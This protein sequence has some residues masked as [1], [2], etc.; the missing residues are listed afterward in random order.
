[1]LLKIDVSTR[2]LVLQIFINIQSISMLNYVSLYK[3]IG[4]YFAVKQVV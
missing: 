2:I 3:L 1:M 4:R